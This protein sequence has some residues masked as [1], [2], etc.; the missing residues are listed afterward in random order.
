MV[1]LKAAGPEAL[2]R[3]AAKVGGKRIYVPRNPGPNHPLVVA[4]G[5]AAADAVCAK[6]GGDGFV[7]FPRGIARIRLEIAKQMV[8]EKKSASA[9]QAALDIT[10]RHAERLKARAKKALKADPA[11]AVS[12]RHGDPR[13]TDLLEDTGLASNK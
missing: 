8:I 3:A 6:V 1:V 12:R 11:S 4:L 7:R 5:R 9:I 10:H 2:R 13:Q